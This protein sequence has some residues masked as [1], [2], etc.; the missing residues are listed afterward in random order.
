MSRIANLARTDG[1]STAKRFKDGRADPIA[2]PVYWLEEKE[3]PMPDV[4]PPASPAN[5]GEA[6]R[7]AIDGERSIDIDRWD[8]FSAKEAA[9]QARAAPQA[10]PPLKPLAGL[11]RDGGPAPERPGQPTDAA[12]KPD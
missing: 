10:T 11:A 3:R 8:G 5:Q 6:V 12:T 4:T 9:K 7:K 2:D 1:T